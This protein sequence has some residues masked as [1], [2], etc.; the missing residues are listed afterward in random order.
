ML[1]FA[2]FVLPVY[3]AKQNGKLLEQVLINQALTKDLVAFNAQEENRRAD[4]GRKGFVALLDGISCVLLI[5]PDHR[6]D[7]DV[8]KCVDD[9]LEHNGLGDL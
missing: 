4:E 7:A 9:A 8:R 2:L 5:P 6:T 3:Q 1:T